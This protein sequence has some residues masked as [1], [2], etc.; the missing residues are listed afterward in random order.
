MLKLL[1]DTCV[2]I[3]LAKDHHQHAILQALDRLVKEKKVV[4]LVPP[5]LQNE[6]ERNKGNIVEKNRLSL[7]ATLK[8]AKEVLDQHG[9][10][11]TKA[12]ALEGLN[13]VDQRLPRLGDLTGITAFVEL[14]LRRAEAIPIT[15]AAKLRA[16]DR[17]LAKKAPFHKNKN[18]VA[19]AMLIEAFAEVAKG[20]EST[21]HT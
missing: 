18:S 13:Y 17:A 11:A 2:W 7:S 4:V 19:D 10:T 20:T 16:A 6:F 5:L 15:D 21:G 1:I 9:E 8:R 3:D 12:Q 14:L